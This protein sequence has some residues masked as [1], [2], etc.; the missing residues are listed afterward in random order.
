MCA[1]RPFLF[2]GAMADLRKIVTK[3]LPLSSADLFAVT[4]VIVDLFLIDFILF[5]MPNS[6]YICTSANPRGLTKARPTPTTSLSRV[7]S[8]P[9]ALVRKSSAP[10]ATS[11]LAPKQ[12]GLRWPTNSAPLCPARPTCSPISRRIPNCKQLLAK[13]QSAPPHA[14][15]TDPAHPADAAPDLVARA[16]RSGSYRGFPRGGPRPCRLPVLAAPWSR[17]YSRSSRPQ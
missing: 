11:A 16:C 5:R 2:S 6:V 15:L 3:M 9:K 17:R 13:V 4:P 7:S 1:G 12:S 14:P 8:P 10:S